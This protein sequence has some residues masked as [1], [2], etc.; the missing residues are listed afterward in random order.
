MKKKKSG[1]DARQVVYEL[2]EDP[3]RKFKTAFVL[4]SI[5]PFLVFF[6]LVLTEFFSVPVLTSNVGFVVTPTIIISLLGFSLGYSMIFRLLKRLMLYAA[7]LRESD[8]VKST[9]VATVSH[10]VRNPLAIVK[11]IL[12]NLV[13]GVGGRVNRTQKAVIQRCQQTVDRLIRMVTQLLDLSKIEAGK[14]MVKRL[15]INMNTL[16][17][18]ELA[19]YEAALKNKKLQLEKDVPTPAVRIWGDRDKLSRVLINLFDNAVKYTPEEGKIAVRLT[20]PDGDARIE[21]E[22]TGKG[23][24]ASKREK[25]FDKFERISQGKELGT[26]LGLSI[27]KDIV[28]MHQGRI[29][30]ESKKGK[31][32]RFI[33]LLPGDLRGKAGS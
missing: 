30:V 23:I 2:R 31:G 6:Y 7:K 20:N 3:L 4:M 19:D 13:D 12:A 29:W 24:P 10:E 1:L 18:E 33:V 17:D 5:I 28:N 14:S 27:A 32:S 21:I 9:L 8:Q 25:V 16:I 15:L 11:L 26:G 22:D